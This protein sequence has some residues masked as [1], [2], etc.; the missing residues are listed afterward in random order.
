MAK[1]KYLPRAGTRKKKDGTKVR[2]LSAGGLRQAPRD[3]TG[4][5]SA[6]N[7]KRRR[8]ELSNLPTKNKLIKGSGGRR[9]NVHQIRDLD[10]K[11]GGKTYGWVEDHPTDPDKVVVKNRWMSD[12]QQG[13]DEREN[14]LAG[15]TEGRPDA[16]SRISN[17]PKYDKRYQEVFGKRKRGVA[18]G[19]KVFKKKYK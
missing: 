4:T 5:T 12:H 9:S 10:P 18:A 8:I 16:G 11:S 2:D 15:L 19:H 3:L 14:N 6:A 7:A 1:K 13:R 17:K